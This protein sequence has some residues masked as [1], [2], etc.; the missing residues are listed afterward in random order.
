ML[1]K[2]DR[3]NSKWVTFLC[4]EMNPAERFLPSEIRRKLAKGIHL[5]TDE[6]KKMAEELERE[7]NLFEFLCMFIP[8]FFMALWDALWQMTKYCGA[9]IG[10]GRFDDFRFYTKQHD[11]FKDPILGI[12]L[13]VLDQDDDTLNTDEKLKPESLDA[14][15]EQIVVC[16]VLKITRITMMILASSCQMR[17]RRSLTQ[18]LVCPTGPC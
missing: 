17:K 14:S 6:K 10:L 8:I 18:Y 4:K 3:G 2:S 7:H 15:G 16:R 5:N 9:M 12:V 1:Q 13:N 11:K